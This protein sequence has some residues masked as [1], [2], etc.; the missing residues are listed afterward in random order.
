[1]KKSNRKTEDVKKLAPERLAS[2]LDRARTLGLWGIVGAWE[3]FGAAPWIDEILDAEEN[4]RKRRSL[5]RRLTSAKIGRFTPM[6]EFDWSWPSKLERAHLAE[7]LRLDFLSEGANVILL[8]PNGVGKTTIAQNLAY[9]ALLAGHTVR[10]TT[11]SELLCDLA[12]QDGT[13][14]LTR[15]IARYTKP[16]LLVIDELG[17]LLSSARHAD[18]LFEIVSRRYKEHKPIVI[19]TN[20]SFSEWG[21]VFPNAACVVTLVDRLVHRSEIIKIEGESY[22]YKESQERQIKRLKRRPGLEENPL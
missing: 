16:A 5:E 14:A 4:E 12:V 2:S 17:Y 13:L 1:V 11:A 22:R 18:L 15:R 7:V 10:M 21:E 8:G 6:A 3:E 19:T 20:K 9:G